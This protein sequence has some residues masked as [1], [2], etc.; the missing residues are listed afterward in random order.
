MGKTL[1]LDCDLRLPNVARSLQIENDL[2]MLD[3]VE[4]GVGLDEVIGKF[5]LI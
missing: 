3:Y 1:L 5:I 4:N 2:G